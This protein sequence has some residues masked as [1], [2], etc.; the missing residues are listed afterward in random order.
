MARPYSYH[1]F[2]LPFEL[3][4]RTSE[5]KSIKEI[6]EVLNLEYWEELRDDNYLSFN[7]VILAE[8]EEP[9][10]ENIIQVVKY[11]QEQYFHEN[12]KKAIHN[13][14][15]SDIVIEFGFRFSDEVEDKGKGSVRLIKEVKKEGNDESTEIEYILNVSNIR[16]KIFN[17]GVCILILELYNRKYRDFKSVKEINSLGRQIRLP[18]VSKESSGIAC[19]KEVTWD[20][21]YY[22]NKTYSFKD[23]NESFWNNSQNEEKAYMLDFLDNMMIARNKRGS[24]RIKPSIDDRMFTCCLIQNNSL[25]NRYGID[26]K[27]DD[28]NQ[29][30]IYEKLSKSLYEYIYIDKEGE[31]SA[32]TKSFRKEILNDSVYHRWTERGSIYGASHTSFVAIT[33][34]GDDLE[35]MIT[36]PFLTQYV[37]I[38][39]LALVQR[40]SILRF[41][42][43]TV[44][45]LNNNM[46]QKLQSK[47][48]DYRNQL[49][50]FEVSSQ[51]QGIELYE[52]I[53]KQL[54]IEKE[55]EVLE[56]NL[57][58]L[59]EKSNV[60]SSN[61]FNKFGLAIGF[62]AILSIVLDLTSFI[63][64]TKVDSSFCTQLCSLCC[65]LLGIVLLT[66]VI[67]V[68]VWFFMFKWMEKWKKK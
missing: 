50:F 48:I 62:I 2:L 14:D 23:K 61:K 13:Y 64:D 42:K 35:A 22:D 68:S 9:K 38:A 33:G 11:N 63:I 4:P 49:H 25:S 16:L 34:E 10:R 43:Q 20:F 60:D 65:E 17:T 47:Y 15:E 56:K 6:K 27:N 30:R 5:G 19:A 26:Y 66:G 12:V 44:G 45:N 18:Y 53:R 51:E 36:R 37:E 1:T 29:M 59:Y 52:L 39:I 57:A 58:V 31:C 8:E 41:Q 3:V 55:M 28:I 67:S 32:Q 40:A 46:I 7:S 54:Y 24:Y 21:L